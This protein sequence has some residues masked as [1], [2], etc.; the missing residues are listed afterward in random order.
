MKKVLASEMEE[1]LGALFVKCQRGDALRNALEEMGHHQT[2]TPVV[3]DSATSDGFVN[4]NIRQKKSREIDM[5][6]Y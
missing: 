1:E 6:F 2:P 5:I 4:N 3:T